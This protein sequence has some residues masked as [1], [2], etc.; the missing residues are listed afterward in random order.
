MDAPVWGYQFSL[1][2]DGL[3]LNAL[4]LSTCQLKRI[5]RTDKRGLRMVLSRALE[6]FCW[7]RHPCIRPTGARGPRKARGPT[8]IRLAIDP[9]CGVYTQAGASMMA[10][11]TSGHPSGQ[12]CP[13]RECK[14]GLL[15]HEGEAPVCSPA[16]QGHT[17]AY[18]H[19]RP[20]LACCSP[21]PLKSR[22]FPVVCS[23]NV[24]HPLDGAN[25]RSYQ[26]SHLADVFSQPIDYLDLILS[27]YSV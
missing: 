13:W 1:C 25:A 4:W 9:C 20:P 11:C 10:G 18:S 14:V 5:E 19:R 6:S 7:R 8:P 17:E 26:I 27:F 2:S 24:C 22:C 15:Q 21:W 12:L 23:G 16:T 3:L